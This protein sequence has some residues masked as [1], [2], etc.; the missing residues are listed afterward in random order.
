MVRYAREAHGRTPKYF[1]ID[2][3]FSNFRFIEERSLS[4]VPTLRRIMSQVRQHG[5]KTMVVERVR[6]NDVEELREENEAIRIRYST[7]S[8][9]RVWRLSFFSEPL[10]SA[11]ELAN[12]LPQHFLGY[13]IIKIDD[14][15]ARPSEGARIYESV[16]RPSRRANNFIRG[17]PTWNCTVDGIAMKTTGYLYAQQ[18]AMTNCC[19]HVACRTVAACF[20]KDRDMS[21]REINLLLG[22]DHVSRKVG[23]PDGGGLQSSEIAAVLRAAG[24]ECI[25]ADYADILLPD[26][27]REDLPFQKFIY[28]S[29]ES[30]FPVIVCFRAR[31]NET[32]ERPDGHAIPLFGHTFNEDTWVPSAMQSYFTVGPETE[33]IPS[34]SWVSM[35]I[36]HDDNC[37][38]NFCIPRRFLYARRECNKLGAGHDL[39]EMQPECVAH[40]IATIP[41]GVKVRPVEA[42]GIGA[43]Y[44]LPILEQ[45]SIKPLRGTPWYARLNWYAER[46]QLVLRPIL[47][48]SSE[49]P[50]HLLKLSDW[51]HKRL[52]RRTIKTVRNLLPVGKVWM[53]ELSIPE[54]FSANRRKV[55]EVLLT[56]EMKVDEK[57]TFDSFVIARLPG[58]F[59]VLP[60]KPKAANPRFTFHPSGAVGHVQLYGCE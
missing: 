23:G 5:G 1:Q 29:I 10:T 21:Y 38:S 37:G 41:K 57:R 54:L 47:L 3:P 46:N 45:L 52:Y 28:G 40:I 15:P 31:P 58:W 48:D 22:I 42:E 14:V 25:R 50:Q 60:A 9:S 18:N 56:A 43:G 13:T 16:I 12:I 35:Y 51:H 4:R 39:C 36:G 26:V 55:A 20:H 2:R 53:I 6:T 49:Y 24:A 33:Y 11:R 17:A 19:A 27:K 8:A 30:G 59:A 7:L 44:L 34:E 32:E